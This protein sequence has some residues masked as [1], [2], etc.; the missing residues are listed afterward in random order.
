MYHCLILQQQ[1]QQ[2]ASCEMFGGASEQFAADVKEMMTGKERDHHEEEQQD[3][4][5]DD[6]DMDA[7]DNDGVTAETSQQPQQPSVEMQSSSHWEPVSYGCLPEWLR[8]N[9]LIE[10]GHRPQLNNFFTC[11]VSVFRVHSET[12]NIWTHLIG[13]RTLPILTN[14]RSP[15]GPKPQLQQTFICMSCHTQPAPLCAQPAHGPVAYTYLSRC[16]AINAHQP[17]SHAAWQALCLI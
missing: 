5:D 8:D 2:Q 17:A 6:D 11:L 3:D 13:I 4:E 14:T 9:E 12:G 1:Q 10:S 16:S 7:T 15:D